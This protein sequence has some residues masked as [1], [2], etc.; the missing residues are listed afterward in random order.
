MTPLQHA[1]RL[2]TAAIRNA[3]DANEPDPAPATP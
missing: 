1:D 2:N 3:L